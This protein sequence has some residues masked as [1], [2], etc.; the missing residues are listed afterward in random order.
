MSTPKDGG[1]AFPVVGMSQRNGQA[2]IAVFEHGMSLRDY[3]AAHAEPFPS[4]CSASWMASVLGWPT[5]DLD[6]MTNNERFLWSCRADAAYKYMQADAM[7][8]ARETKT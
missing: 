8:E 2:L 3:F 5:P 7:I 4:D 6:N 1:P